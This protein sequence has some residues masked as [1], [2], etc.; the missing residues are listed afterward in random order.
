MTPL[1]RDPLWSDLHALLR[2]LGILGESLGRDAE[3][4]EAFL[5]E[6]FTGVY[7]EMLLH[8]LSGNR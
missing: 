1:V 8:G 6:E 2:Q 7:V 3:R 4:S 5:S